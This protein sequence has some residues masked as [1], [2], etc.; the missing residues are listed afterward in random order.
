MTPNEYPAPGTYDNSLPQKIPNGVIEASNR[1][2]I[3]HIEIVKYP[4]PDKYAAHED[5]K[6][7][8]TFYK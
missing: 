4:S 1:A 8:L 6:R 7:G 3:E 2:P 5:F